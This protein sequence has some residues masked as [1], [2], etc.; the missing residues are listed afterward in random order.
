MHG[1][2]KQVFQAVIFDLDGVLVDS[3]SRWMQAQRS[4][5][6]A[7]GISLAQDELQHARGRK[8]ADFVAQCLKDRNA[9]HI[10]GT[11][12]AEAIEAQ[13]AQASDAVIAFDGVADA[14]ALFQER[15]LKI[16]ICSSSPEDAVTR[17]L[18]HIGI[19]DA[20][21]IVIAAEQ[22]DE[23]KP[24]PQPYIRAAEALHVDPA[25]CLV[26]EDSLAGLQSARAAGMTVVEVE[27]AHLPKEATAPFA[28][29]R[30]AAV[31]DL[32]HKQIDMI[33]RRHGAVRASDQQLE[34]NE[35]NALQALYN[36]KQQW[37]RHYESLL[38]QITPLSTTVSLGI[39][40][41][42][43]RSGS[44]SAS[45]KLALIIPG[46]LILFT[47]WFNWWCDQEIK[48]QFA[49]IVLAEKGLGFYNRWVDGERVLPKFYE[50]SPIKTRPIIFAGYVL[51][52]VSITV[53]L[54]VGASL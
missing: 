46:T 11:A 25:L 5:F 39:I 10:D 32:S 2:E 47:L 28:D 9:N 13:V 3:D 6:E 29:T 14:F 34:I 1:D 31:A 41:Y 49:Q 7:V 16:A 21:S 54:F 38:A 20:V 17:A 23:T 50:D 48:R 43:A 24:S 4:A 36:N 30:I 8:T 26:F 33:W 51:Q 37:V 27:S 35:F 12:I 19:T 45:A 18:Q 53:L 42:V 44:I 52:L 40:A 22:Q 15:E